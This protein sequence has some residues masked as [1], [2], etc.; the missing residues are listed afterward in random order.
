MSDPA[1]DVSS[2]ASHG[3]D[4]A[5]F[6]ARHQ[7]DGEA[8]PG[9]EAHRGAVTHEHL[10]LTF[11]M[12]GSAVI[13]QHGQWTIAAGDALLIPAGA[14][15][16][17][18]QSRAAE[19]W[20]LGL[21]PIGFRAEGGS[22]LLEPFERVRSGSASVVS[23]PPPRWAFLLTLFSE[24]QRE[25]EATGCRTE[26]VQRSLVS[27]LL[28]EVARAM[29]SRPEVAASSSVVTDALRFIERHCTG[30]ISLQDVA[31]AVR[32]SPSYVTTLVR[33]GTGRSVQAWIIAGRL[34]EARR[35]LRN[36]DELV[37]VIAERVG[38]ADATH[39]IRLF[40]REH[41]MTPAAFRSGH[42][43]DAPA[44]RPAKPGRRAPPG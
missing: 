13:E 8:Q 29:T 37:E 14:P 31:S 2:M 16:R 10:V 18:V 1:P 12:A 4:R 40:R 25:T 23:I 30:P 34:S 38:Y 20:S 11:C 6:V 3:R 42:H 27:L 9:C 44:A 24:L 15:H 5:I 35:R 22:E 17:H 26:T 43:G 36:T 32:R 7:R 33:R 21:C 39:F 41:G 28:N 19:L